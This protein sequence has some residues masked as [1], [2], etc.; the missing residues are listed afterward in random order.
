MGEFRNTEM[1][2]GFGFTVCLINAVHYGDTL[3]RFYEHVSHIVG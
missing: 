1:A 2:E 3:G